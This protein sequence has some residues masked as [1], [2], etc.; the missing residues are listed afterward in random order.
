VT[1]PAGDT[2][3]SF[4]VVEENLVVPPGSGE[5][6]IEVGLGGAGPA[7]RPVGRGRG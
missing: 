2:Q 7:Q 5:F 6:E 4:V 1:I 3:G